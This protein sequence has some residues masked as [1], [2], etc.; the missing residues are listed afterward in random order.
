MS[1][2]LNEVAILAAADE[3][4]AATRD[5]KSWTAV[6]TC[7]DLAL[8]SRVELLLDTCAE[9][10]DTAEQAITVPNTDPKE[11]FGRLGSL[12]AI[13]DFTSQTLDAW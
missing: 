12:L 13:I 3:L 5:A 11:V 1:L 4:A 10:A 8:E 7:P 6:N 2:N 9:A